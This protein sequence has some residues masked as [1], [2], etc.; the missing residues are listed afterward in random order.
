MLC[1]NCK[2]GEL[3]LARTNSNSPKTDG[4]KCPKCG[5]AYKINDSNHL[6]PWETGVITPIVMN[7]EVKEEPKP[8]VDQTRVI[9]GPTRPIII[10]TPGTLRHVD[11]SRKVAPRPA[12]PAVPHGAI[13]KGTGKSHISPEQKADLLRRLEANDRVCDIAA[14]MNLTRS[15][16][17]VYKARLKKSEKDDKTQVGVRMQR[18]TK[19]IVEQVEKHVATVT[20][21]PGKMIG[22]TIP[23]GEIGRISSNSRSGILSPVANMKHFNL[24][25]KRQ[26]EILK[27][28]RRVLVQDLGDAEAA[29]LFRK[30]RLE[31][32]DVAIGKVTKQQEDSSQIFRELM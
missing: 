28:Y 19:E 1:P 31:M 15:S 8:S 23:T 14:D 5:S 22:D 32:C 24:P 21:K 17:Y 2:V 3:L 12:G 29:V 9:I 6:I 16:V 26:I 18:V 10:T 4:R 30:D 13:K 20:D 27:N 11:N 25:I 7:N